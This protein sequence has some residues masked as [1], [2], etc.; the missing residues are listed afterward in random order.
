METSFNVASTM[1]GC[2]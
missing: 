1:R 2:W